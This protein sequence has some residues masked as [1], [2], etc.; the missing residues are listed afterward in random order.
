M[1]TNYYPKQH[2]EKLQELMD[3]LKM[4]YDFSTY[5]EDT[6]RAIALHYYLSQKFQSGKTSLF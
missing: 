4:N 1:K 3:E 2:D 6:S 5:T